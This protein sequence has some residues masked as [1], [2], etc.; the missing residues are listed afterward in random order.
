MLEEDAA[1][2]HVKLEISLLF[3]LGPGENEKC[4]NLKQQVLKAGPRSSSK[5]L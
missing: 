3:C 4:L 1:K 5:K 2:L